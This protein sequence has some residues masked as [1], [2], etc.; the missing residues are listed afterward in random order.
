[1]PERIFYAR[2]HDNHFI[3]LS[4]YTK[5]QNETDRREV[6]RAIRLYEDWIERNGK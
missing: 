3:L 4:H 6:L 5:R 2:W 1:M